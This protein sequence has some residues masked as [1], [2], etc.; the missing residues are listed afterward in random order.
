[1]ST[2]K[3]N[4]VEE[5]IIFELQPN[6]DKEPTEVN[7]TN[8]FE[9]DTNAVADRVIEDVLTEETSEVEQDS[10]PDEECQ[11]SVG[12]QINR[13]RRQG[14]PPGYLRDFNTE[15]DDSFSGGAWCYLYDVPTD[16]KDI[17]NSED[18]RSAVKE[19]L[20]SLDENKTWEIVKNPG[21]VKLI[22]TSGFLN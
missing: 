18:W 16:Y 4:K 1:M 10:E 7:A 15:G 17:K 19:E 2:E 8:T 21:K 3:K 11:S 20:R 12:P 22:G 9:P 6:H 14:R 5:F 13:P